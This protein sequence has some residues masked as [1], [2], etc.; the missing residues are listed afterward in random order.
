MVGGV[1]QELEALGANTSRPTADRKTLREEGVAELVRLWLTDPARLEQ[2][3]PNVLRAFE[4]QMS[5]NRPLQ[6]AMLK[7]RENTQGYLAQDLGVRGT[8]R[9]SMEGIHPGEEN[10][11]DILK[12]DP[13][14]ARED[15]LQP[16]AGRP[17]GR[18][19]HS[20]EGEEWEAYKLMQIARYANSKAEDFLTDHGITF[21]DGTKA[22]D[23]KGNVIGSL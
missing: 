15:D 16:H 14:P 7:V 1:F 9:I 17:G 18:V 20:Q 5:Q 2:Q 19:R 11:F 21:L 8:M 10:W 12:R 3:F 13:A 4:Q 22:R 6:T 23:K